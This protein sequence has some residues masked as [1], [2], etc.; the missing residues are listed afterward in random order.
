MRPRA[1]VVSLMIAI[2]VPVSADGGY[3]PVPSGAA[4]TVDQRAVI[5]DHGDAETIVLQTAYDGDASGFAWVI[6]VPT[7]IA[8][9]GA[10]GTADPEI[11]TWLNDLT[12]PRYWKWHKV[13]ICGCSGGSGDAG[14]PEMGGVTL[15]DSF[16]V[17]GYN[18]AVLSATQSNDLGNWLRN[19]GYTLPAG[20]QDALSYYVS[21]RWFFVALK[22]APSDGGTGGG[23][24][25]FRPITITFDTDKLVFP[26][27]ISR[28]STR[29]R[30]EVLLYVL[31]DHRVRASNYPTRTVE[32]ADSWDGDNFDRAYDGWFEQTIAA[33]GG[34][35][36]VV[37]FAGDLPAWWASEPR[38][39]GLLEAEREYV[40]TRLRT[41]LAP[42]QMSEDIILTAAASDAPFDVD[43]SGG[44]AALRGRTA[45]A[46]LLLAS[47]QG[48]A[49]R[50]WR[51]G[52]RLAAATALA[53]ILLVLL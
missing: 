8:G 47:V 32:A 44:F 21:K 45:F 37:E 10:I 18:V 43:L 33:A 35:A 50:R 27:R 41:R 26:L 31:S 12:A 24:E 19:N 25:E 15:W 6:P 34:T 53:G 40:V 49:L 1:I 28:V 20:T 7:Q 13:G 17:D 16:D 11:F 42:A 29:E 5:I 2:S 52:R 38:F 9:A 46:A 30:A 36:L 14:A 4:E 51:I 3:F 23:G 48:L 22:I 39:E